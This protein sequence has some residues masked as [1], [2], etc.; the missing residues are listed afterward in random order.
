[1]Q[2]KLSIAVESHGILDYAPEVFHDSALIAG[3]GYPSSRWEYAQPPTL[4][5]LPLPFPTLPLPS[6]KNVHLAANVPRQIQ[7]YNSRSPQ[8]V[9]QG[10]TKPLHRNDSSESVAS[11]HITTEEP[12]TQTHEPPPQEMCTHLPR[13]TLSTTVLGFGGSLQTNTS[14]R[15]CTN[16]KGLRCRTTH[17]F[18]IGVMPK[19]KVHDGIALGHLIR[20]PSLHLGPSEPSLNPHRSC[21]N[22][23][24][25]F[26][27]LSDSRPS[28]VDQSKTL[29][30]A[31]HST[32]ISNLRANAREL[33]QIVQT[34][35]TPY[36][37]PG[38]E[39][40]GGDMF[41]T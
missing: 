39:P 23:S 8:M 22:T 37:T 13:T 9:L 4:F 18:D 20:I 16:N 6:F 2:S 5:L 40:L 29:L 3:T 24:T 25:N 27:Q 17:L 31:V 19:W 41:T 10:T 12:T 15:F 11:R 33:G 30:Q 7:P 28:S 34:V 1:M 32:Q 26:N 35:S 38:C 36:Q 21:C 14:M